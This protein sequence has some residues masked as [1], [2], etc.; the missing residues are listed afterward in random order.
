MGL[1]IWMILGR[2]KRN[3]AIVCCTD[4]TFLVS[5]PFCLNFIHFPSLFWGH[6]FELQ[7][8]FWQEDK[9]VRWEAEENAVAG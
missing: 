1:S 3:E 6:T 5:F 7:V 4:G 8:G 9:F 2:R